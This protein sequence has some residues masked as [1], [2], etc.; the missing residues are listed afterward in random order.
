MNAN[1]MISKGLRETLLIFTTSIADIAMEKDMQLCVHAI[2]D[3][4]NREV[5]NI[6][7]EEFSSNPNK[8]DLRWRIEHAQHLDTSDIPR[9]AQLGI[10]AMGL[11][12]A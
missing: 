8:K 12:A 11:F 10:I 7:D 2:G 3:R 1:A 4:A 5:I 9:F 6:M